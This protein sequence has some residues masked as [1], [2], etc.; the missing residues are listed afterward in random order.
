MKTNKETENKTKTHYKTQDGQK[1][2]IV[3][4]QE[5]ADDLSV[6]KNSAG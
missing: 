6:H 5:S 2:Q 3:Q 1:W 4:K